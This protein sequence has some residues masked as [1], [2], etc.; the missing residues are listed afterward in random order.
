[1]PL[2]ETLYG[3]FKSSRPEQQGTMTQ[4]LKWKGPSTCEDLLCPIWATQTRPLLEQ[5]R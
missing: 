1:M 4:E 3:L 2:M 5:S